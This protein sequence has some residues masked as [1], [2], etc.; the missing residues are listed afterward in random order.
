MP[1]PEYC[2]LLGIHRSANIAFSIVKGLLETS[3]GIKPKLRRITP[4]CVTLDT[5]SL[6]QGFATFLSLYFAH[7][8]T[9]GNHNKGHRELGERNAFRFLFY[10]IRMHDIWNIT[11][12]KLKIMQNED[13]MLFLLCLKYPKNKLRKH[14]IYVMYLQSKKN[15]VCSDIFLNAYP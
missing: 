1:K 6:T 4:Q 11:L 13:V 9:G 12:T 7:R 5:C 3:K 2:S 8:R 10:L 15:F 14:E